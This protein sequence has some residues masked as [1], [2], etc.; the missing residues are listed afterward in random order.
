MLYISILNVWTFFLGD[1]YGNDMEIS[2]DDISEI[3]IIG[4]YSQTNIYRPIFNDTNY[5][6]IHV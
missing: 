5:D 1:W 6:A 4:Y 3:D 2:Q